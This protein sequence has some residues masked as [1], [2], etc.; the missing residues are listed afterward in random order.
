MARTLPLG[1]RIMFPRSIRVM[2]VVLITF[3][4]TPSAHGQAPAGSPR[5]R[6]QDPQIQRLVSAGRESSRSFAAL[7][8]RLDTGDV[9]V[10]V[11]C[12]RLRANVEG[13][14]TFLSAVAGNRYVLVRLAWNLAAARKIAILGH[15]LQ[16][17]LEIAE[18]PDIVDRDSL[19]SAYESFGFA[20]R[21]SGDTVDFD[22]AAAVKAGHTIWRELA[23]RS[24][25]D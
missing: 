17:A 21:R 2:A 19:E 14:L 25:G 6:I 18:R 12:S 20:R 23:S 24:D 11:Q 5:L 1:R 22:T 7:L 10:Y 13:E 16:H 4:C 8:D 15:E 3:A 9:V